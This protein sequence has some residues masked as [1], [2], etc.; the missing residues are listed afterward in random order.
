MNS[1]AF[2]VFKSLDAD[3]F[4]QIQGEGWRSCWGRLQYAI[5]KRL[6]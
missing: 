4:V 6:S 2:E 5:I 1:L 3:C